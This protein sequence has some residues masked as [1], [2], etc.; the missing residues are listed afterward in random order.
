MQVRRNFVFAILLNVLTM[1][2]AVNLVSG[3]STA[4]PN[5]PISQFPVDPDIPS[6]L[7]AEQA[8]DVTIY[9]M[10]LVGTPYRYGGNTPAGGFDCS[11]LIGHVYMTQ[12]D[13]VPPR[14]VSALRDWGQS[15]PVDAIR[16]GD[17][18]IFLKNGIA[19]HAGIYVGSGR[20]VHAPS[21]GGVVRL[22]ILTSGYWSKQLVAYRRP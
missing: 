6:R 16:T 17:L 14:T 21:A 2:L 13:V 1:L 4:P 15:V 5:Q 10:S 11:G 22:E 7:S 18:A 9:A 3:C 8:T 20:F 12:S 19:S